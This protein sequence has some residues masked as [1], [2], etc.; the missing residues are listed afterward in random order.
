ME[1]EESLWPGLLAIY[2]TDNSVSLFMTMHLHIT[3]LYVGFH[4]VLSLDLY[5]FFYTSI[6]FF[7][8]QLNEFDILPCWT[9]HNKC[10]NMSSRSTSERTSKYCVNTSTTAYRAWLH[11]VVIHS[12]FCKEKWR[13]N[14]KR[15]KFPP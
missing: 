13:R 1:L 10:K 9:H 6:I 15:L 12:D 4:K 7:T 14:C 11:V 5:F 3:R 8:S 2:L